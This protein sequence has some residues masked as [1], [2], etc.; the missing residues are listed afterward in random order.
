MSKPAPLLTYE[1][2]PVGRVF[3]LGPYTITEREIVEFASQYDPQPFHMDGQS[4]QAELVGGLIASGWH[5]CSLAM[6]M[7]CDAYLLD[8]ASLGSGGLDEVRWH[9]PLRP[10][11]T[12]VGEA[13]VVERRVSKKR[14]EVGL[15]TFHYSLATS[16]DVAILTM[17]GMGMIRT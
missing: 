5:T 10:G 15:V 14:P 11:D 6:R 8:T 2:F 7:M 1:D 16:E 12:L 9:N 4:E 17:K 13:R 3:P